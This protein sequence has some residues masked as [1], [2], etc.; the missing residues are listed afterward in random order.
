MCSRLSLNWLK[1]KNKEFSPRHL[2]SKKEL[3]YN[4][5]QTKIKRVV[6]ELCNLANYRKSIMI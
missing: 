3:K 6:A 2:E 1:C 5:H 4:L